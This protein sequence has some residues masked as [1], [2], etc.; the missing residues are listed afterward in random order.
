ML[1]LA[2]LLIKLTDSKS[3]IRFEKS[4]DLEY[5]SDNPQRRCPDL[6]KIKTILGFKPKMSLNDGLINTFNYYK[7]EL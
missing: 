6:S 7:S 1:S 3:I 4:S 5:L 2:E